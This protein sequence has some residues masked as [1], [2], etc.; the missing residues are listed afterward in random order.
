MEEKNSSRLCYLAFILFIHVAHIYCESFDNL[1]SRKIEPQFRRHIIT[2]LRE[3]LNDKNG[4]VELALTVRYPDFLSIAAMIVNI[5][6][7]ARDFNKA[8]LCLYI[9]D[10]LLGTKDLCGISI[11]KKSPCHL[12]K[13]FF[14]NVSDLCPIKEPNNTDG[15]EPVRRQ[16]VTE[17]F[18]LAVKLLT[19]TAKITYER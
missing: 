11:D 2:D 15:R 7:N 14:K 3:A 9:K 18:L 10:L 16:I 13:E 8:R 17:Y 6:E 5:S 19:G 1:E 12:P 4:T